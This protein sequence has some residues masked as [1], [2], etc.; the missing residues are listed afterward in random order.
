MPF[1]LSHPAA[2]LPLR[3]FCPHYVDLTALFIGCLIPD[4]GYYF[5]Q[6]DFASLA[7]SAVGSLVVCL[8]CGVVMLLVFRLVRR[9]V[10]LLLPTPHRE[11]IE[12]RFASPPI[13]LRYSLTV[14]LS[15]LLGAWTHILW[16]SWTHRSGWF[17]QRLSFLGEPL[18]TVGSSQFHGYYILQQLSTIVGA[19]ILIIAYLAWFRRQR[20][21]CLIQIAADR[22]RYLLW[23]AIVAVTLLLALPAA[24]HAASN[25]QG[26][27]A[28]RVFVFELSVYFVSISVSLTILASI[29]G[30][31]LFN[32]G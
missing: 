9:P 24:A 2:V 4:L 22:W 11:A 27:L 6:F 19:V 18:F 16:D 12:P 30:R 14:I 25:F 10:C 20:S 17:V 15:L 31:F 29:I 13:T 8:P 21:S 28:F 7:H 26:Y 5:H 32:R 23:F 3:R 1:T